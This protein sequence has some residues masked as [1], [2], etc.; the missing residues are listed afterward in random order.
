MSDFESESL[1]VGDMVLYY[2]DPF[3]S[4]EP[5]IGW[6]VKKPGAQ[7]VS[8]LCFS[9]ETGFVE[10]NSVRHKDDPFWKES[11]SAASWARWGCYEPHPTTLAIR[12]IKPLVTRLKVKAASK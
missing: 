9:A 11:E 12:E 6:I 4:C 7:T 3:A 1:S 5:L 2:S 10:K 8:I